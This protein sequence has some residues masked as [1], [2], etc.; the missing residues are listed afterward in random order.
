MQARRAAFAERCRPAAADGF[1]L[2][3]WHRGSNRVAATIEMRHRDWARR[4]IARAPARRIYGHVHGQWVEAWL[5]PDGQT[6]LAQWAGECEVPTA[7]FVPAA[8]GRP[9][10]VTGER[11]LG[12][13]P[14]SLARGWDENGSAR[15]LLPYGVCGGSHRR[16]GVYRIEPR[17]G[18]LELVR[19]VAAPPWAS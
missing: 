7:F 18:E 5:S 10:P 12:D 1:L 4:V 6:L 19:P 16:P 8:G 17:K 13:A 15:V 3:S 14:E 11:R 9:L 2:C